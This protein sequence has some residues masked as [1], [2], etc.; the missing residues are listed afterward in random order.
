MYVFSVIYENKKLPKA[1]YI[2][3]ALLCIVTVVGLVLACLSLYSV[4]GSG[5]PTYIYEGIIYGSQFAALAA[6]LMVTVASRKRLRKMQRVNIYFFTILNMVA[7]AVQYFLRNIQV[8]NF[9]LVFAILVIYISLQRPEDSIDEVSGLFNQRTF[10]RR[11]S[12][13]IKSQTH[14][15]VF[16]ME[17]NN[18][19]IV[20]STFGMHGG[21]EIIRE[22]SRRLQ[23]ITDKNLNIYRLSGI[24]FA[25]I[26]NTK[27][28]Y[29]RFANG[30]KTL[31]NQVFNVCDTQL[32]LSATACLIAVP[33]V[34]DKVGEFEDL[35]KYYR[36]SVNVS[37]TVIIADRDALE[38]S[39]RRELVDYAIQNALANNHF[40]VY[41]QPIYSV[42]KE[43]FN[44]CE[45][46]IRLKD[47]DLGFIPPDEF[48]PIAEQNGRIVEVGRYVVEEV[49]RFIKEYQPEQYGLE[50]IDVNLSVIQ[51]MHPEIIKDIEETMNK[52]NVPRSMINLEVTETAS[53]KSYALLQTR[54]NEL[55][56][57]GFTI[58][59]DDFG[60]GFSSVEYL[61][62]F[63]FDV[64]KLDKS[65]VWAYMSTKKYE[66]ILQHYMPMLHSLGTKIVAEGVETIEMVSALKE[67]GCDYMQGYYYSRPIPNTAFIAFIKSS[68]SPQ[69]ITA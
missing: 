52:Y 40:E 6:S 17:V 29:D 62:N 46:L 27:N 51:C 59:L 56:S 7:V 43:C 15:N 39:R 36:S 68:T 18:M 14:F 58:S 55:H 2:V 67:L 32:H 19:S 10:N 9:G 28:E 4:N 22:V 34:T 20:N 45:A 1:G 3:S 41:Y 33:E 66:P 11:A 65:L 53:A 63:P 25:I 37:D 50:C 24:R 30:Y 12:T 47:P 21:N 69:A 44:S 54:L 49:C 35:I 31:F 64:V 16:V 42:E 23:L 38:K 5:V 8:C 26:F 60:T 57:N 61:I 13:L 48:I